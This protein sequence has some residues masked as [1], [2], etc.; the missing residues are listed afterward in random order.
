[1]ERGLEQGIFLGVDDILDLGITQDQ[2]FKAIA[3]KHQISAAKV[4]EIYQK[5]KSSL[6]ET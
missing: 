5:K 1:M 2:A 6:V 3:S 4:K